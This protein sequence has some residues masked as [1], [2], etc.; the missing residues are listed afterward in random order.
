MEVATSPFG[1]RGFG[2][3]RKCGGRNHP[4]LN[5]HRQAG[6]VFFSYKKQR[7]RQQ[8]IYLSSHHVGPRYA[9][10]ARPDGRCGCYTST[11]VKETKDR[12][13]AFTFVLSFCLDSKRL[14]MPNSRKR[15][16]PRSVGL[17]GRTRAPDCHDP[18]TAKIQATTA[19]ITSSC[20]LGVGC[21]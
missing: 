16:C 17:D 1:R 9:R 15:N 20:A 4:T 8:A 19:T 14:T 12:R 18:S 3:P 21:I 13:E 6:L 5:S 11:S 2:M 7:Q 10:H